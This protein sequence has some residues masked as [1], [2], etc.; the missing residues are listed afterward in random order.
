MASLLTPEPAHALLSAS[1]SH[2]W[3]HCTPSARLEAEV[4]DQGSVWAKEGSLAH[5]MGARNLKFVFGMN[6]SAENEEIAELSPE[7]LTD[8]M[9][10]FANMY[11]SFVLER[12]NAM[13]SRAIEARTLRPSISIERR[14]DFSQWVPEGFGTGDAVLLGEGEMEIID[15]K[16]G[17]GV[18]VESFRNPQMMIYALASFTAA[19]WLYTPGK[20][21]MTIFQP[22][23]GHVSTWEST[24]EELLKW[25]DKTLAPTAWEA[26]MGRGNRNKGA[27]CRFCKVKKGCPAHMP[28][29]FN[30]FEL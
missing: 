2:K 12:F 30:G 1:G 5:A 11:S 27:W 17:K 24:A 21:T 4:P 6:Y 3:L 10:G 29:A 22:R 14:L 16:Y 9:A 15:L 23:L 19:D 25:A 20:V 18:R 26:W 7:F 13:E 28:D 8:E